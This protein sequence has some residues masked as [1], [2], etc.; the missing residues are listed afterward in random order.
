MTTM[1]PL[2]LVLHGW[3]FSV[4]LMLVLW[5]FERARNDAGVVDLGWC[6]GIG[7]LAIYYA[8][9]ADGYLPRR[10]LVGGLAAAW[11]FRLALYILLDRIVGKEE[12]GRYQELRAHWGDRAHF[13]FFFFFESQTLLVVLFSLPML[14]LMFN[15][16]PE[17]TPWELAGVGVWLAS[18]G[19]ESLADRQLARFRADTR[20]KGKVCRVGLWRYSRHPNYFFEWLHW[21]AYVLMGVGVAYGWVTLVGPVVMLLFLFKLTGIPATEKHALR[22]RGEEYRRYQQTT[23]AFIPWFPSGS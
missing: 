4:A 14:V 5:S 9:A 8:W 6:S 2:T 13:N 11:S 23:S 10:L 19:G 12:D 3:L 20:N 7:I 21:W 22:S 16:R 18:V 15:P 17:I 1:S